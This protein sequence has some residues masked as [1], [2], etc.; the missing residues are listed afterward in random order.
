MEDLHACNFVADFS[1][2]MLVVVSV[3]RNYSIP[4]N[5]HVFFEHE[6][7]SILAIRLNPSLPADTWVWA[8]TSSG[9]FSVASAYQVAFKAKVVLEVSSLFGDVVVGRIGSF[10]D[11]LWLLRFAQGLDVEKLAL[12]ATLA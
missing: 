10:M 5:L 9:R 12:F 7:D 11:L 6:A 8:F 2:Y 3:H 4:C 1:S